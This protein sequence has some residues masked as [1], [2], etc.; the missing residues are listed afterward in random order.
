MY[1][2][3][4]KNLYFKYKYI[5]ISTHSSLSYNF[6]LN[7]LICKIDVYMSLFK[8]IDKLISKLKKTKSI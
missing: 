1:V 3:K 8:T 5:I 4:K 6:K 2:G 7:L